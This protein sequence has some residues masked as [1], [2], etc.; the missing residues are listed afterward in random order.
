[1]KRSSGIFFWPVSFLAGCAMAPAAPMPPMDA[2]A[3]TRTETATFGL[4]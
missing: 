4:G 1:M 2:A 3:P